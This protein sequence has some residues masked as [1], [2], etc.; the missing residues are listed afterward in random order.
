MSGMLMGPDGLLRIQSPLQAHQVKS[1]QVSSKR[2]PASCQEAGCAHYLM[3]WRTIVPADSPQAY[4]IRSGSGRKF[5]EELQPGGLVEFTFEAGQQCFSS[6]T[7]TVPEE[8]NERYVE[9]GGDWRGNPRGEV[10]VHRNADDWVDSFANH[11]DK[12]ATRLEQG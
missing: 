7:H 11:Q 5:T 10:R 2:R 3:G 12:L 8:G 4:Y 9:R 1:Y 6:S